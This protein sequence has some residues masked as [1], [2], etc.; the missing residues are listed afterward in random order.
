MFILKYLLA[1]PNTH[2][3]VIHAL[4]AVIGRIIK[5]TFLTDLQQRN[6]LS[7]M[8]DFFSGSLIYQKVGFEVLTEV[9]QQMSTFI[10][11]VFLAHLLIR[12]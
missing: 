6:L 8:R 3:D 2:S 7:N 5:V 10:P 1:H 12:N 9:V 11:G 4:S